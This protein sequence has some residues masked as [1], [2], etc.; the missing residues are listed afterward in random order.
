MDGCPVDRLAA[1][2]F[3]GEAALT[4]M[5]GHI[6]DVVSLG[7][8]GGVRCDP[9]GSPLGRRRPDPTCLFRL[10]RADFE[11]VA[12]RFPALEDRLHEVGMA[13]VRRACSPQCSPIRALR[14]CNFSGRRL[15]ATSGSPPRSPAGSPRHNPLRFSFLVREGLAAA[16]GAAEPCADSV[17]GSGGPAVSRVGSGES[18][19]L[20]DVLIDDED[21]VDDGA[22]EES[23]A[24]SCGPSPVA[25]PG[26]GRRRISDLFIDDDDGNSDDGRAEATL[27]WGADSD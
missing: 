22:F 23:W 18:R 10:T 25:T 27:D 17:A 13:R 14:R 21:E 3:F 2:S 12:E 9:Q 16:A 1:G 6:A 11:A 5:D 8:T 4:A 26:T 24:P 7:A 15:V 20:S 19:R